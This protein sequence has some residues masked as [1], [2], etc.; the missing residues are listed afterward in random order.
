MPNQL[1]RPTVP[2]VQLPSGRLATAF[3]VLAFWVGFQGVVFGADEDAPGKADLQQL[4]NNAVTERAREITLP[5]GIYVLKAE[6]KAALIDLKGAN[7]LLIEA[8]GVRLV[9][10]TLSTAV[11]LTDCSRIT[12]RGLTIDYDPL[13][14]TQGVVTGIN[15]KDGYVDVAIDPGYPDTVDF[16]RCG[17]YDASTRQIKRDTAPTYSKG[18]E[19][20]GERAV[21]VKVD[22]GGQRNLKVGDLFVLANGRQS[23]HGVVLDRCSEITLEDVTLWSAPVLGLFETGGAGANVYRQVSITP[24]PAPAGATAAR[25]RSSVA[26][27][28]HSSAVG[29]GPLIEGCLIEKMADD[30]I[31]IHGG[32]DLLL[33][34]TAAG[35]ILASKEKQRLSVGETVEVV[36]FHGEVRGRAAIKSIRPLPDFPR[37]TLDRVAGEYL[38]ERQR[39]YYQK[40]SEIELETPIP[41]VAAGDRVAG[42]AHG[43]NGFII[44]NNRIAHN[45]A[46]GIMIRASDGLIEGNTIDGPS[47]AGIVLSPDINWNEAGFSRNVVIR[48]NTIRDAGR[49]AYLMNNPESGAIS[50]CAYRKEGKTPSSQGVYVSA[51]GQQS[52]LISGNRFENCVGINLLITSAQDIEVTGNVFN[53]PGAESIRD[54]G[55]FGADPSAVI[56][57]SE[58]NGIRFQ[59][60]RI[61]APEPSVQRLLQVTVSAI[62]V[63]GGDKMQKWA[64]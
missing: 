49:E 58:T 18:V 50:I 4:L 41:G 37:S 47:R 35:F 34:P 6:D 22:E 21:R 45:R 31:A 11:R 43:G 16:T 36:G 8:K 26:D 28:I 56:W 23:P 61:T 2:L 57:V 20:I 38:W 54:A 59:D 27:G 53:H 15:S 46:R 63:S 13:P 62:N 51:G 33:E 60:N 5:P 29:K 3:L 55:G 30:G 17:I 24:G 42:A 52:I 40:A 9:G 1:S 39:R 48:K 7:D 12:I 10:A 64:P 14:F 44:R 25:L 32:Y 19:R